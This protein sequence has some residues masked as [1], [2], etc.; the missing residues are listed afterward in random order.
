LWNESSLL[1][2]RGWD[3]ALLCPSIRFGSMQWICTVADEV[4]SYGGTRIVLF[5]C[6]LL[7]AIRYCLLV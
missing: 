5:V 3:A 4:L 6:M 7:V 1:F 2:F